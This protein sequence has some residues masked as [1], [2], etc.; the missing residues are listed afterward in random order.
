MSVFEYTAPVPSTETTETSRKAEFGGKPALL[1]KLRL[2]YSQAQ[3]AGPHR[4]HPLAVGETPIGRELPD[5]D[6]IEIKDRRISRIHAILQVSS[7]LK[8]TVRDNGSKNG[9]FINGEPIHEIRPLSDG[10]LLRVGDGFFVVRYEPLHA[11]D[12]KIP[13]LVGVSPAIIAIRCEIH[14]IAADSAVVLIQGETGTGKEM[15]AQALH[16]CSGRRGD[17]IAVN[18]AAIPE[19]LA[20]SQ[21]FGHVPNA[22]TGAKAHA[23]FFRAAHLGTLFLDEVGELPLTL[24][25]KLLRAIQ[26]KAVVPVGAVKPVPCDVRLL[27]A[28]NRD[29]RE[30][31]TAGKFREDLFARLCGIAL[32][33]PPLRARRE[34]ILLLLRHALAGKQADLPAELVE[35]LLLY[36]WPRNV[37]EVFQVADHLRLLGPDEALFKRLQAP[38]VSPATPV[39]GSASARPAGEPPADDEADDSPA[40]SRGGRPREI[41][42]PSR[43]RLL[44]LLEKHRGNILQMATA[45]G[46]SRRQ[47]GRMLDHHQLDRN[48]FRGKIS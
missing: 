33:M 13:S 12:E 25:A 19:T 23:G 26:D 38:P 34:D 37:R 3:G 21:L 40:R 24:Q 11:S 45:L 30:Q 22:F 41:E 20:E 16:A 18:C 48:L 4:A 5:A 1:P 17:F 42:M 46:C 44:G 27:S 47:L 7:E 6:G 8:L 35:A 28:T 14:R 36:P 29:L 2:V 39:Q 10:D 43:E 9:T 32:S 31:V 15:A